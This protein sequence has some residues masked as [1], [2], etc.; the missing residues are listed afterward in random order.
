[1]WCLLVVW[2]LG[3]VGFVV[4]GVGYLVSLSD[5]LVVGL[6]W[7]L[8]FGLFVLFIGCFGCFGI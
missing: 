5:V 8:L 1:M 4:L 3:Y 7:V 2:L 6:C